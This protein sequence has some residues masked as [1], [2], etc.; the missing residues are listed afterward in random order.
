MP[1]LH[2]RAWREMISNRTVTVYHIRDDREFGRRRPPKLKPFDQLT[3]DFAHMRDRI[4]RIAE[5]FRRFNEQ[6]SKWQP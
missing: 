6:M 4:S 5:D 3:E 2:K 1:E